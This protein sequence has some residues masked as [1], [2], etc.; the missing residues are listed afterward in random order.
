M[1][2]FFSM[3]EPQ[4]CFATPADAARARSADRESRRQGRLA[5]APTRNDH[6]PQLLDEMFPAAERAWGERRRA[7]LAV[8]QARVETWTDPD[9]RRML[10]ALGFS[11]SE[12]ARA[13]K[14]VARHALGQV[15]GAALASAEDDK[16]ERAV[17]REVAR[18]KARAKAKRAEKRRA[19]RK[20]EKRKAK[21]HEERRARREPVDRPR[22][23]HDQA[24]RRALAQLDSFMAGAQHHRLMAAG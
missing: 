5:R 1:S 7:K 18:R 8:K 3:P 20:A 14:S 6:A 23:A 15:V 4:R 22:H 16:A 9:E 21:R 12:T 11:V 10:T 24:K 2:K 19:R 13:R 17:K